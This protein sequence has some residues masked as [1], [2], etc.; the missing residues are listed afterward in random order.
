MNTGILWLDQLQ[1]ARL[2]NA[3][4]FVDAI[5][6]HAGFHTV[7][8]EY[9]FQD[10]PTVFRMGE[11]A[12][13]IKFSAYVV[14]HDYTTARERLRA[15][16][17]APGSAEL[18]HPTAGT[19]LVYVAGKYTIKE[20]PSSEGGIARFELTFV[21]GEQRRYPVVEV[22]TPAQAFRAAELAKVAAVDGFAATF[23]LA[24][25]PGW[26]ADRAVARVAGSLELAW[27]A[28]RGV[29]GQLNEFTSGITAQ[30]GA[31]RDGLN[32]LVRTPRLL[33]DGVVNLLNLPAELANAAARDFKTAMQ[34]LFDVG[35]RLNAADFEVAVPAVGA[36]LAMFGTGNADSLALT[37]PAR[38]A[39]AELTG[40]SDQLLET[41]AVASWVQAVAHMEL[42]NYD[43]ALALRT[44]VTAQCTRLLT[45]A[46]EREAGSATPA[47][48]DAVLAL[49]TA[50]LGD[51]QGRSAGLTRLSSYTPSGWMPVWVISYEL[52]GTADYADEI[53]ALNPSITRPLLVPPGIAL[54]VA[55]HG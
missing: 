36:G 41:V 19:M 47:W 45:L 10:L 54:R 6:H 16:L 12:E 23:S 7:V 55:Q 4:F 2:R 11:A 50:S 26:V 3:A 49:L 25:K 38:A 42:D 53:L 30:Y 27:G 51:V 13:E 24:G 43:E 52:Y 44:Q 31:L 9:P 33:A 48:H 15:A 34:G 21:R 29:T 32:E 5:E 17:D 40:A 39:L 35:L 28:M 18:V 46:S 22:N 37:S 1:P 20:A 14:G 8:R